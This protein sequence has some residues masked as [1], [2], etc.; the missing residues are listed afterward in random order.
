LH[1]TNSLSET[2]CAEAVEL[3]REA[4]PNTSFRVDEIRELLRERE[5]NYV[6]RVSREM[7]LV[8]HES[9]RVHGRSRTLF[10]VQ[11]FPPGSSGSREL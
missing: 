7:N 4:T 2:D 5:T 6:V 10:L 3:L 8:S 11:Q 1:W 9:G